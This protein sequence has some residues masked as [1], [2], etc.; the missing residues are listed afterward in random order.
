MA[1]GLNRDK[2][3]VDSWSEAVVDTAD[4]GTDVVGPVDAE[5]RGD[6]QQICEGSCRG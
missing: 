1:V 4:R 5:S 6:G 2:T 3:T